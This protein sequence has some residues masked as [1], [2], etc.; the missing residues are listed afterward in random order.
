M[1]SKHPMPKYMYR[2]FYLHCSFV[3]VCG[4]C[5]LRCYLVSGNWGTLEAP[6]IQQ[7]HIFPT[8]VANGANR[9]ADCLK[10]CECWFW[11]GCES[12]FL[13]CSTRQESPV[14]HAGSLICRLLWAAWISPSVAGFQKPEVKKINNRKHKN[15]KCP[16]FLHCSESACAPKGPLP[17][18]CWPPGQKKEATRFCFWGFLNLQNYGPFIALKS[19][20]SNYFGKEIK[21]TLNLWNHIL[22][23]TCFLKATHRFSTGASLSLHFS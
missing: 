8:V 1:P 2:V 21:I 14:P 16:W 18:R 4:L 15:E 23:V 17:R 7:G 5:S 10:F 9:E 6:R 11:G 13:R 19:D 3:H 20:I 22:P 12:I